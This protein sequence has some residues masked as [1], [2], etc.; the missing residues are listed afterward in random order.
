MAVF[1]NKEEQARIVRAIEEA[2]LNTSGEIRVHVESKCKGDAV[3]RAI[4]VFNYLKMYETAQRNGV[5]VYVAHESKKLAIIGDVGINNKVPADFWNK[6]K[7]DMISA[8]STGCYVEGI[9]EAVKAAGISLK[10]YFPYQDDDVNEQPD[11]IS[12]G[13]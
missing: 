8:F 4:Y 5:L 9:C 2:E 7:D 3:S 12:F 11:E 6:I 10:E 13:D 1:F